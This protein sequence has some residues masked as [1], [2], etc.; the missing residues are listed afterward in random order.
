M[1][2]EASDKHRQ[3]LLEGL[4]LSV[5]LKMVSSAAAKP[6]EIGQGVD[7][8]MLDEEVPVLGVDA[9]LPELG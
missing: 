1:E 2:Y 4:G 9:E 8:N 7:A 5:E 3:A 6:E